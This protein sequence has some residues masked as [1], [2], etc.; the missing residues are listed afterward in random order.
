MGLLKYLR[1]QWDRTGAA[2]AVLLGLVALQLGWL[3]VSGTEYL[4]K[5]LPYVVSGGLLGLFLLG[6]GATLWISA[7]LRD[8][9]RQLR[10]LETAVRAVADRMDAVSPARDADGDAASV[11]DA[12]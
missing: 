5:Q 10:S 4:A 3:G 12:A 9:W 1:A 11:R 8:E 2:I 7:D 6:I